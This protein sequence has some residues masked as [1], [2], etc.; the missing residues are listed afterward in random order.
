MT[1]LA[2]AKPLQNP[3]RQQLLLEIVGE[4]EGGLLSFGSKTICV[5]L[6]TDKSYAIGIPLNYADPHGHGIMKGALVSGSLLSFE[7]SADGRLTRAGGCKFEN[8]KVVDRWPSSEAVL[9]PILRELR[10]A[11]ADGTA[12]VPL[13]R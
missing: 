3:G 6:R 9:D 11:I 4:K 5:S 12:R 13:D 2:T 7:T 8:E 1:T 10:T